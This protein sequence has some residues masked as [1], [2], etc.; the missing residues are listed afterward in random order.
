MSLKLK[1]LPAIFLVFCFANPANAADLYRFDPNHTSINFSANHFGFSNPSGKFTDI[2]GTLTL[3]ENN[4]QNSSVEVTIKTAAIVTG[5]DKFDEHLKSRDFLYVEQFP[6]AKFVSTAVIPSGKNS[7]KVQGKLSLLGFTKPVSLDVRLN[8]TGLNP[9]NQ[10]KTV[11]FSATAIIKRSEF[12]IEF[13]LPGVSDDVKLIIESEA[14]LVSSYSASPDGMAANINSAGEWKIMPQKS[15][16]EFRAHHQDSFI[17]GSFKRFR[18]KI[19][20]DPNQLQKSQVKIDIDTGSVEI[21]FDEATNTVKSTKWLAVSTFPTATFTAGKF[22][23]FGGKKFRA[24]GQLTIKG[25]TVPLSI[26][27]VFEEYSKIYAR[28]VGT[29]LIKRSLFEI[30][31]KDPKKANDIK[32]EVDVIFTINA[33]K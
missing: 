28:A 11:G 33:E 31:D 23:S 18:G 16:I 15:K 25:N 1:K 2:E 5:L 14:N 29:A 17:N 4:P 24:D 19:N 7:A 20:F 3:D 30:G 32:D 13:G 10:R 12:G 6:T 9:V 22:T 26:D 21:S 8:K 27:F